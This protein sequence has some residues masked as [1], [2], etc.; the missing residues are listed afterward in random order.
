[1][2]RAAVLLIG[3]VL[4]VVTSCQA[5]TTAEA[6]QATLG[7]LPEPQVPTLVASSCRAQGG[8]AD[9]ACTPGVADPRVTQANIQ[10]TICKSGWSTNVRPSSSYTSRLKLR[11]I[12]AYGLPGPASLYEEDH[13]ISLEVGGHP[14]D[15][16]NLFPEA[17]EP[18]PGAHEK[19]TVENYLHAQ[20]CKGLM[21]L[22][23]A[24]HG[25]ATDWRQYIGR[26]D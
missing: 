19:D 12:V 22:A 26:K 14:T 10:T 13:W 6:P 25:E 1:M 24:Q 3:L 2:T 15:P 7:P 21:Q 16:K 20:V 5:T 4:A 18:R 23:V 17:Y 8:L 9:P 11:Q